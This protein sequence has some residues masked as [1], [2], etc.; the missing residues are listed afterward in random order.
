M[1]KYNGTKQV[2]L[3]IGTHYVNRWMNDWLNDFV[4]LKEI[5]S[6]KAILQVFCEKTSRHI[7]KKRKNLNILIN[8][9]FTR[10]CYYEIYKL[11]QD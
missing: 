9:L 4:L 2:F 7:R 8:Q 3:G 5:L 11:L 6:P 1:K 10:I